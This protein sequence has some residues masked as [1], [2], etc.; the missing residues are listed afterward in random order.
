MYKEYTVLASA[1]FAVRLLVQRMYCARNLSSY[2]F[3]GYNNGY[4]LHFAHDIS[5]YAT[6]Y[7]LMSTILYTTVL[8]ESSI[9]HN[10]RECCCV[11]ADMRSNEVV[12][13][14][15]L[16]EGLKEMAF[17]LGSWTRTR[18]VSSCIYFDT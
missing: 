11:V 2:G 13:A 5:P 18:D 14:N 6:L 3:P 1:I 12:P 10:I 16:L 15:Y 17:I 4:A 9:L 7:T 8:W